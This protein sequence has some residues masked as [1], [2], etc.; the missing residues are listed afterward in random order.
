MVSLQH[1]TNQLSRT[2]WISPNV[3]NIEARILT[4]QH[5]NLPTR[6]SNNASSG[7]TLICLPTATFL[8][9]LTKSVWLAGTRV[10]A[11]GPKNSWSY[12]LPPSSTSDLPF[13]ILAKEE[14]QCCGTARSLASITIWAS[15]RTSLLRFSSQFKEA[16]LHLPHIRTMESTPCRSSSPLWLRSSTAW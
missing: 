1:R 14:P 12:A 9:L 2:F 16:S 7:F 3:V 10:W 6:F 5:E 11:C 15:R 13:Q 8:K 4:C